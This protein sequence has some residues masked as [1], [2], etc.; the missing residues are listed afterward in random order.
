MWYYKVL[1]GAMIFGLLAGSGRPRVRYA[2]LV[3]SALVLVGYGTPALSTG[4]WAAPCWDRT[5]GTEDTR[6]SVYWAWLILGG[7]VGGA[8]LAAIWAGA[9]IA[10]LVRRRSTRP[11]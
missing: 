9:G 6:S 5:Y 7:A 11:S 1:I 3:P 8:A 10:A 2:A 4:L